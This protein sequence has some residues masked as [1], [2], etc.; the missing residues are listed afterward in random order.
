MGRCLRSQKKTTLVIE[1]GY[2]RSRALY[3]RVFLDR[4]WLFVASTSQQA[5]W[6]SNDWANSATHAQ[7]L[8]LLSLL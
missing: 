7:Q 8:Q 1:D 2:R 6:K 3:R 5:C 4:R